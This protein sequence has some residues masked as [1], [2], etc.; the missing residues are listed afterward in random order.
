MDLK[1]GATNTFGIPR[2]WM[3]GAAIL[4]LLGCG[5]GGG[6][7][8]PTEPNVF[9]PS[10][11]NAKWIEKGKPD[12]NFFF[13][14]QQENVE[15][16]EFDGNEFI[17]PESNQVRNFLSGSYTGREIHFTIGRSR[18]N[19]LFQGQ[20]TDLNNMSLSSSA[21]NLVLVRASG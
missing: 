12:H 18:G 3:L 7:G 20:F 8:S 6:G 1:Q 11:P 14:P 4:L 16:S 19:V 15:H 17:G 9:I 21:G 13:L 10:I 5:G 2:G